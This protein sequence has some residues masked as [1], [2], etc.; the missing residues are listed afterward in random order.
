MSEQNL[1]GDMDRVY[2]R[3]VIAAFFGDAFAS[4]FFVVN[5]GVFEVIG[6]MVAASKDCSEWM[7]YVPRPVGPVG[8]RPGLKW[9]LKQVRRIGMALMQSTKEH[10][11][12]CMNAM[13]IKFRTRLSEA[14]HGLL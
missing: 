9:S 1:I 6:E 4:R 12:T 14:Q 10:N 7:E 5:E 2:A 3:K 8:A 13:A 11:F